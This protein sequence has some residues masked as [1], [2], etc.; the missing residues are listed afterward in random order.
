VRR[1]RIAVIGGDGVGPEVIAQG[2]RVLEAAC[3][4]CELEWTH[5]P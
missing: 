1:H 4:E 5:L 2:I 3:M